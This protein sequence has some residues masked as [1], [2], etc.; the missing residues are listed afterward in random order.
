MPSKAPKA[1]A[2]KSKAGVAAL[3][4]KPKTG[5]PV[6]PMHT[7]KRIKAFKQ[8]AHQQRTPL[9][10]AISM[11]PTSSSPI[12]LCFSQLR[13]LNW[14]F[15]LLDNFPLHPAVMVVAGYIRKTSPSSFYNYHQ[16]AH[17]MFIHC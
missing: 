6:N 15:H 2:P 13:I 7:Y 3:A 9:P 8:A 10:T 5:K 14:L 11:M 17:Q 16:H 1:K 4:I 12:F